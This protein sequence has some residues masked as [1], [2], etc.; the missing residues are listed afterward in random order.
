MPNTNNLKQANCGGTLF[1][2]FIGLTDKFSWLIEFVLFLCAASNALWWYMF[3]ELHRSWNTQMIF[4]AGM[5]LSFLGAALH[6][7]RPPQDPESDSDE[8]SDDDE[9]LTEEE[10]IEKIQQE[11][12]ELA[13]LKELQKQRLDGVKNGTRH[14]LQK[15]RSSGSKKNSNKNIKDEANE[16]LF[17][18]VSYF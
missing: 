1:F 3:N 6:C 15:D 5:C 2:F 4:A 11:E 13:A 7:R 12:R 16:Y 14:R 8:D 9:E 17:I 18:E 10:F